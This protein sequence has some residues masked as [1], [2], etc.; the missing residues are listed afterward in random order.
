MNGTVNDSGRAFLTIR[1][2]NPNT[3][4][5][6][7]LDTWVDT[8]FT[9]DLVLPKS[10]IASLGLPLGPTV[11]AILANGLEINIDTFSC[12]VQWF[13]TWTDVEVLAN[14]GQFPLLGVGM[15]RDHRLVIDYP[16]KSL[17]LS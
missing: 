7:D 4:V 3:T 14:D 11:R 6:S 1:L 12:Q 16:R 9:G 13:G 10:L 8:G 5:E 15:L 17:T 2:R